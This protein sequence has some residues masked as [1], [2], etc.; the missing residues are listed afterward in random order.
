MRKS[1]AVSLLM[2]WWL[3]GCAS[4]PSTVLVETPQFKLPPLP[5][6]VT[7]KPRDYGNEL[8]QLWLSEPN[9]PPK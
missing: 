6:W 2:I 9:A 5:A 7:E 8:R 3:A 4:A 1:L